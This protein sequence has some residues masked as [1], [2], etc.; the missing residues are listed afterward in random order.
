MIA[1]V[2]QHLHLAQHKDESTS[3]EEKNRHILCG[4][5]GGDMVLKLQ[6]YF[7]TSVVARANYKLAFRYFGPYKIIRKINYVGIPLCSAGWCWRLVL[8]CCERKILLAGA[9]AGQQN[10]SR[11]MS[12]SYYPALVQCILSSMSLS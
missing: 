12:F 10:R 9:G 4:R 11:L 2:K 8:D 7:Q 6:P 3:R 5:A 1:L